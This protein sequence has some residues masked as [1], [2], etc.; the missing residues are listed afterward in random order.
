MPF[1]L[2]HI[3]RTAIFF[4]LLLSSISVSAQYD[5]QTSQY[6]LAPGT[7][8]PAV[9]GQDNDMLLTLQNRQQW[10]G[11]DGAP[12]TLLVNVTMPFVFGNR[13]HG[14]GLIIE[15]ESIGLFSTQML[16][17]QYAWKKQLRSGVL[18]IGIQGG[19]L[20][21]G[22]DGSGIYIPTSDY[23]I[24]TDASIPT[25]TLDGII[26]DFSAG[27]WFQ[28]KQFYAG[29]SV[30][31]LL[32]TVVNLKT[33]PDD[34]NADPPRMVASR[35]YYLTNGYNIVLPNTLYSVQPSFLIKTDMTAWQFDLTGKVFYK[36]KF[37]GGLG[38]RYQDA[39]IVLAGIKLQQGLSIGYSYDISTSAVAKFSGGSH[40]LF[41]SYTRKIGTATVSKRQKSVRIL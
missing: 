10:V 26:P 23:H 36:D 28:N 25:G 12:S 5:A 27:A 39:I 40:E 18:S 21:E 20:Q 30:S 13:K 32:E 38:W 35:T 19:I 22:F 29:F 7:F 6:M 8:N 24:T 4:F 2:T 14:I 3:R 37:W 16:Q 1:K 11:I 33:G 41:M 17:L 34:T 9:A 31:H 15:K